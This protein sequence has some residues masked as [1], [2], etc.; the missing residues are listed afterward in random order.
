MRLEIGLERDAGAELHLGA[1][2]EKIGAFAVPSRGA[3]SILSSATVVEIGR[4]LRRHHQRPELAFGI[5][6]AIGAGGRLYPEIAGHVIAVIGAVELVDEP[7]PVDRADAESEFERRIGRP[8]P[9]LMAISTGRS[10]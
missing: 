4:H 1:A 5:A 9:V 6:A 3:I 7:G 2:G 8:A 10:R